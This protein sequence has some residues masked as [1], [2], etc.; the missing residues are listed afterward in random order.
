M[1]KQKEHTLDQQLCLWL[2]G[3]LTNDLSRVVE[4]HLEACDQCAKRLDELSQP[5]EPILDRLRDL[6][7]E[8]LI[9]DKPSER[10][11]SNKESVS[12]QEIGNPY[13]DLGVGVLAMESDL[14]D[15]KQ[16][17]EAFSQWNSNR[18]ESFVDLLLQIDSLSET[19]KD[20][21]GDL[22]TSSNWQELKESDDSRR[23]ESLSNRYKHEMQIKKLHSSGGIGRVWLAEDVTL[24]RDVALKELLPQH[25]ES[26]EMRKRFIREARITAQLMHPGT[27]PVHELQDHEGIP[28]YVMRFVEGKTLTELIA[29]HHLQLSIDDSSSA[30]GMLKLLRYF[31]SVCHTISYAHSQRIIHRDIKSEN[32][33]V[34][35]FGEVIVLDWGI[36]KHLDDNEDEQ[37]D[38]EA[39]GL[40]EANEDPKATEYGQRLGTPAFM[41]P[42][43]ALG[44]IGKIDEQTDV[45]GL[46]AL[47]Y[48]ILTGQPPYTD[49]DVETTLHSVIHT[50]P[51]FPSQIV[52]EVPVEL[53]ATCMRG[54]SKR[55]KARQQSVEELGNEVEDWI[56]VQLE[57]KQF[58]KE[59]NHF[60]AISQDLQ[61][62]VDFQ[63]NIIQCNP[64]CERL[65][66]WTYEEMTQMSDADLIHN[67]QHVEVKGMREQLLTTGV[68][69]LG[70][71]R[72]VRHKDGTYRWLSWNV[73]PM[74]RETNLYV[75][76]RDITEQKRMQQRF[77]G[78]L[79]IMPDAVVATNIK[80]KIIVVNQEMVSLFGYQPE[81]IIGSHI[82]DIVAERS[83][84]EHLQ[85]IRALVGDRS[86]WNKKSFYEFFGQRKDGTEFKAEVRHG[87]LESDDELLFVGSIRNVS[88]FRN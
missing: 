10:L 21:I 84:E 33:I 81:E 52:K 80:G 51:T 48:E 37:S 32:I 11:S 73:T 6:S 63:G 38:S 54:L 14:I 2:A 76:G 87:A 62:I 79:E 67:E 15:G 29:E 24:E 28:S 83:H 12:C 3:D 44:N 18:T 61:A 8:T 30:A 56:A 43:Q 45:Y 9:D 36:A 82:M 75:V 71:E 57:R 7:H 34:G 59:R 39:N 26:E 47:L 35:D 70:L 69:A 68:P 22:R 86:N 64:A 72:K 25:V 40:H 85:A 17:V 42:E 53:E 46:A 66:G 78:L 58:E 60:F 41:A 16:F 74:V 88:D 77:A 5:A 50:L 1:T 4:L 13:S 49:E 55:S 19:Q 65:L 31:S 23:S 20:A 27:V